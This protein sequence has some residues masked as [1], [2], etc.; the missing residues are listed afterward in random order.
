MS[1]ASKASAQAHHVKKEEGT[2]RRKKERKNDGERIQT[3]A[4]GQGE[5]VVGVYELQKVL[6]VCVG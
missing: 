3:S 4:D 6:Q 2:T 5:Q 1:K